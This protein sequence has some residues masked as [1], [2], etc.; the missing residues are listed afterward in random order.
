LDSSREGSFDLIFGS[1]PDNNSP[2]PAGRS[3]RALDR[4]LHRDRV[5]R[6]SQARRTWWPWES[7]HV[8]LVTDA[9]LAPLCQQRLPVGS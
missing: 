6:G 5:V 8:F 3:L 2:E 9:D 1:G 4:V 7:S